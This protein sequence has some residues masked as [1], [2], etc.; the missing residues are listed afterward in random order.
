MLFF[1]ELLQVH[2]VSYITSSKLNFLLT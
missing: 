2:S 1:G